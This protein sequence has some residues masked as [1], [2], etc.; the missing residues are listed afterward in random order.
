MNERDTDLLTRFLK[1]NDIRCPSCGYSLRNCQSEKCP[2]CGATL[3]LSLRARPV[4]AWWWVGLIGLVISEIMPTILLA[5]SLPSAQRIGT[6]EEVSQMVAR[7][8][9]PSSE[10]IEWSPLVQL[11][12]VVSAGAILLGLLIASR[13]RFGG[14]NRFAQMS[15][16]LAGAL[17]PVLVIGL[18]VL[19]ARGY[20]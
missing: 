5:T 14:W 2:E 4:S 8:F 16:G 9:S 1:E 15:A 3:E 20:W 19:M 13:R 7:R 11:A 6:A 10:L 12:I 18:L 17:S